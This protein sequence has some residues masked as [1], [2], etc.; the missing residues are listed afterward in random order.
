MRRILQIFFRCFDSHYIDTIFA[1]FLRYVI[2]PKPQSPLAL[3]PTHAETWV[4]RHVGFGLRPHIP[5]QSRPSFPWSPRSSCYPT[6]LAAQSSPPRT[7]R[8][9]LVVVSESPHG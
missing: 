1:L 7:R 9:I 3:H 8:Q 2:R 5:R 6:S 4:A